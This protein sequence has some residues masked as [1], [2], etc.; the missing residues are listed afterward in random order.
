MIVLCVIGMIDRCEIG[1]IDQD[2]MIDLCEIVM[3]DLQEILLEMI[4][5]EMK[6]H[7]AVGLLGM[8][9]GHPEMTGGHPEMTGGH[10][11]MT[12]GLPGMTGGLPGMTG[13]QHHQER[14]VGE[15]E[16]QH[17]VNVVGGVIESVLIGKKKEMIGGKE[18]I[19]E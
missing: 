19:E 1:M 8:T 10:P 7:G 4:V 16:P 17:K 3:T 14:E 5:I 18:R 15:E 9:G 12:G 11:E 6:G 2:V 13:G